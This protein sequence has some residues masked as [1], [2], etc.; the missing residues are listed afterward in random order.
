MSDDHNHD[1][2]PDVIKYNSFDDMN[3]PEPILRGV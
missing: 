3:L 2:G 1:D